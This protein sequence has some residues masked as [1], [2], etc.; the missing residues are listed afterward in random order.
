MATATARTELAPAPLTP[1]VVRRIA[2]R[3]QIEIAVAAGVGVSTVRVYELEPQAVTP[4]RRR[5][6][7]AVYARLRESLLPAPSSTCRR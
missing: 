4:E 7:D 1:P 6:L 2:G 5:R 3:S